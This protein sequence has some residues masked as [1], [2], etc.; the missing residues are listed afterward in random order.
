MLIENLVR[1]G[2]PFLA[3]AQEARQTLLDITDVTSSQAV[4]FFCNVMIVEVDETRSDES[5]AAWDLQD[6]TTRR[7]QGKT[8]VVEI[9]PDVAV[10][11]PFTIPRG[12]NPR[13]PQGRYPVPAYIV[14]EGDMAHFKDPASV[15]DFVAARWERT[16]LRPTASVRAI[17][18]AV[19]AAMHGASLARAGKNRKVMGLLLIL[20]VGE[21][22]PYRYL[23]AGTDAGDPATVVLGPSRLR[24]G[25]WVVAHLP[26]LVPLVWAAKAE[27]GAIHGQ[28]RAACTLCQRDADVVSIYSKAWPWF[29]PTWE[30]PLPEPLDEGELVQGAGLCP[31]CYAAL[32]QGAQV[33]GWLTQPLPLWLTRELFAPVDSPS[34]REAVERGRVP[35]TIYGAG[36]VLPVSDRLLDEP[37]SADQ[38][39]AGISRMRRREGGWTR[40]LDAVAGFQFAVADEFFNDLYRITLVYYSGAPERGDIHLRAMI[41]DVVPTVAY[42]VQDVLGQVVANQRLLIEQA[43]G[44]AGDFGSRLRILPALLIRAYGAGYVWQ[45]MET[46]LRRRPISYRRFVRNLALRLA[47]LARRLGDREAYFRLVEEVRLYLVFREFWQRYHQEIAGQWP[48]REVLTIRPWQELQAL[49][50]TAPVT[51]LELADVEELGF[52]IGDLTRQFAR[53][54]YHATRGREFLKHRVMTFGTNL[55]PEA[56]I[57]RALTRFAE[58]A[59][60]LDMALSERFRTLN[61]VLLVQAQRMAR[62]LRQE[63]D[64]FL[65]GFWAGYLLAD[66]GRQGRDAEA[67]ADAGATAA[68]EETA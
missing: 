67:E 51:E 10:A 26:S 55:T 23:A 1:L 4:G 38:F 27:E 9:K 17:A 37:E 11:A 58:Y 13:K 59:A 3:R 15:E 40:H 21:E 43:G 2:R 25:Y 33:F 63:A 65:A 66:L 56:I 19:A 41:E 47:E 54:Y 57:T 5:L 53:Q 29:A 16:Q 7:L 68:A 8:E 12:G 34:G 52:A 30:A 48:A 28:I 61:G 62:E 45:S 31:A 46:V 32:T 6:W 18:E 24:P 42:Q 60:R 50:R 64:R 49:L 44:G 36:F 39:C 20:P 35:A 14:Y 22:G